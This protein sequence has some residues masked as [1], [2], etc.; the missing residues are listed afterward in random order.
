MH[1][2]LHFYLMI[3]ASAK[4]IALAQPSPKRMKV[5]VTG[6]GGKTGQLL[7]RKMLTLPS[8][9]D[10]IGIVRTEESKASLLSSST[11][12]IPESSIAVID[13]SDSDAI[14]SLQNL[15]RDGDALCICTSATPK[16]T[17]EINAQTKRPMLGFPNG[18]P[19]QVDW[20]GQKNQIDS[21]GKDMHVVLCSSMGG[22]D[23]NHMLNSIGRKTNE[24]GTMSGGNI[25]KWKRKAEE[26]LIN[27]GKKYTIVHPGG[28]INEPGGERE[29]VFGV[30]DSTE[31]TGTESRTVPREDVAEVMLQALRH[32]DLYGDRSFDL[33]AK[34]VGDG[35]V[36]TDFR[37]KMAS[38][39]GKNCDY[40]LG[41]TM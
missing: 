1:K 30:D 35:E 23:P 25:L 29:L 36:T 8:E 15:A 31:G 12:A 20:I 33:R 41:E 11:I 32:P 10:P 19:E 26:Y 7:F 17:G 40:A 22:T 37:I 34:N 39:A 2:L 28:L 38:L 21:C 27:S 18:D 9:F 3:F 4:A 13:V 14:S 24:D 6:A 16:P 5:I